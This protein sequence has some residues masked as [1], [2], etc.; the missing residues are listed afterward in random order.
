M[1]VCILGSGLSALT[2]A[3]ALVNQNIYVD[4]ISNSKN[5]NINKSRTIGISKNNYDYFNH[6]IINIK[7]II[8]KI[9]KI[10]IYSDNLKNEKILN[11]EN[12]NNQLFSIIKNYKLYDAINK[13]LSINKFY[14]KIKIKK[15]S[16]NLKNYNLIINTDFLSL[17]TKKF[18]NKKILKTY[19]SL[20]YTTI[21]DHKNISNDVAV[22]IFTK[23]G[24]LAFLP[25]S[26]KKTSIVYSIH[27]SK[28]KIKE[29]VSRLIE[30]YNL[31]YE[32]KK[33]NK[34]ETFDL[35]SFVLRDYYYHNILAFGDLLHRV[36]PLAGQGFNMT[37][38]D[39]NILIEIIKDKIDL[40]LTLDSSVNREFEN[41]IKH[42]N[43]IFSNGIDLIHEFFNLER[44]FDTSTLSKSVKLLGKNS[45]LNKIFT[46]IADRGIKI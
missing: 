19:N 2:L 33:I 12:K 37:I 11:F 10:E 46:Q 1:R 34:I 20:A 31:K 40:G 13:S 14:K 3:K 27:N 44:K 9:K 21:I 24:P 23:K 38:R 16:I 26:K 18:F 28:N 45:Y 36:H 22:Q 39:I 5:Y 25:I 4:I 8:W 42:K 41:R 30:K 17:Y 35:K 32:I 43:Y 15:K 6:N 7:K 29:N